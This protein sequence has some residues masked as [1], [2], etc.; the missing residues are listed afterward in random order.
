MDVTERP[1]ARSGNGEQ[2]IC[3]KASFVYQRDDAGDPDGAAR[4][5]RARTRASMLKNAHAQSCERS[6]AP[7]RVFC[8]RASSSVSILPSAAARAWWSRSRFS[9]DVPH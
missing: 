6:G 7:P 4:A 8:A 1:R 3:L 5:R 2:A 9:D